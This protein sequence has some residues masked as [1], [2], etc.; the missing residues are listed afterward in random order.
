[1]FLKIDI[2]FVD[3]DLGDITQNPIPILNVL[4][5]SSGFTPCSSIKPIIG[6]I[7]G[8]VSISYP[9]FLGVII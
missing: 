2:I 5:I 6:G 1:M 9:M 3:C 7:F 8:S 4:Y